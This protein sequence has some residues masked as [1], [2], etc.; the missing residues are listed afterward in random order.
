MKL[1][2]H[3]IYC[4]PLEKI[5]VIILI[6]ILL[7]CILG[8]RCSGKSLP[9]VWKVFNTFIFITGC[10][11]IVY[12]TIIARPAGTSEVYLT[13][14]YSYIEAQSNAEMY[15]TNLMNVF[16]FLPFGLSLP[17]ILPASFKRKVLFTILATAGVSV[18]VELIQFVFELG[19]VETDDVIHNTLGAALGALPVVV[20]RMRVKN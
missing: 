16:L 4:Q 11:V 7:W 2:L 19:R 15:R 3:Y 8:R 1:I 6:S 10:V 18:S 20:N 9:V 12:L 13:P 5:A 17:V 14:F